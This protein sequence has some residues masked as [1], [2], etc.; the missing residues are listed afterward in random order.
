MPAWSKWLLAG[1]GGCLLVA[2]VGMSL[3]GFAMWQFWQKIGKNMKMEQLNMSSKPDMP[4]TAAAGE[5]LPPRVGS[6]VRTRVG[7]PTYQT[8]GAAAPSGWE[9]SYISAGKRVE[10]IVTPTAA[11]RA[12]RAPFGMQSPPP[13]QNTGFHMS[14]KTKPTPMDMVVWAKPNW[15]F[16]VQ[17]RDMAAI[18]FAM[19]Y[20][21]VPKPRR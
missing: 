20:Q 6:F 16:M 19:A 12:R 9:G 15:T 21:P 3:G 13:N 11:A 7:R 5:L 10:L 2:M 18:P 14:L 17:S 8:A 4:L 1:C